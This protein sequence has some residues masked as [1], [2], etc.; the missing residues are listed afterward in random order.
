MRTKNSVINSAVSLFS[1]VLLF[2]GPFFVTPALA[3]LGENIVGIQKTFADIV[4]LLS[5]V[6]L[7]IS[8]GII[9]KLYKPIADENFKKVAVLLNFYKKAFKIVSCIIFILGLTT[10][11]FIPLIVPAKYISGIVSDF[12]ISSVFMLYVCDTI[13]TYLFGHERAM[14]IADQKNYIVNICRTGCQLLM[15]IL[16]IAVIYIFKSFSV[17]VIVKL[18]FTV[19]ESLIIHFQYKRRYSYIDLRTKDK[20]SDWEKTDLF[21]NLGALFYHKVGYQSLTSF[22]TVIMT[23]K[24][25]EAVT[26]IYYPYTVITSGLMRVTDQIFSSILSSFGNL[27]AK[28]TKVEVFNV[29]KKIYFL[30]HLIFSFFSVS[31]FCL[32]VPFISLWMGSSYILPTNTILLITLNLYV[33]GMRQ[34]ITMVKNSAGLYRPDRYFALLESFINI[35]LA[36][37]L[38]QRLG[39]NGIL[40]ANLIS[41]IL[42]PF[43]TQPYIVYTNVFNK[44]VFSYYKKYAIYFFITVISGFITF[45]CCSFFVYSGFIKV[46]INAI[47]CVIVPNA[48]NIVIFY[49]SDEFKYLIKVMKAIVRNITCKKEAR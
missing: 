39:L 13:A 25:G 10:A 48:I 27:L 4:S 46:L 16:Q 19:L 40:W 43:W 26:G 42:I 3:I 15:F 20:L 28:A 30:N 21:K 49:R 14:L 31:L 37:F 29:Y 12:W 22:S 11:F 32:L 38:V 41:S 36:F 5:V 33:L 9:Y 24:L 35:I 6:E 7:G 45:Y 2:F 44:S 8:F 1:Y 47:V 18:S 17:Y 23:N 34:S